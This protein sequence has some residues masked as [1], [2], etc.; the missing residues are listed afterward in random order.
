MLFK[1]KKTLARKPEPKLVQRQVEGTDWITNFWIIDEEMYLTDSKFDLDQPAK[2]LGKINVKDILVNITKRGLLNTDFLSH[3]NPLES[4]FLEASK[5]SIE[6]LDYFSEYVAMVVKN[7]GL[8]YV[9]LIKNIKSGSY[10]N[11]YDENWTLKEEHIFENK[12]VVGTFE[13]QLLLKDFKTK[14][15]KLFNEEL[16]DKMPKFIVPNLKKITFTE[17]NYI[18]LS[19]DN[20][21]FYFNKQDKKLN[22]I[23][24]FDEEVMI[25][26]FDKSSF[27]LSLSSNKTTYYVNGQDYSNRELVVYEYFYRLDSYQKQLMVGKPLYLDNYYEAYDLP[28]TLIK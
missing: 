22:L 27:L 11:V 3:P 8:F 26:P 1:R 14:E 7:D 24:S 25:A 20:E 6:G 21:V 5:S 10:V 2:L 13:N 15:V 19:D 4:S 18:M 23:A 12:I 17:K 28:I 9:S 16:N